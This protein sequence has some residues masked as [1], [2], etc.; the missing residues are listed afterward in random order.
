MEGVLCT[1]QSALVGK[2][3]EKLESEELSPGPQA[4]LPRRSSL[5]SAF[6]PTPS[7]LSPLF[8]PVIGL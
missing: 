4:K 6:Q 7:F 2:R 8:T 3:V 5:H 1:F